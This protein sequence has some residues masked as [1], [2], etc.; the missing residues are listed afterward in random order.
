MPLLEI[1]L[2]YLYRKRTIEAEQVNPLSS[3]KSILQEV[4]A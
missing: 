2:F 4:A 1:G 3:P